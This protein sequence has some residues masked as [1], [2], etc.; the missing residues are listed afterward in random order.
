[1][2]LHA[3]AH[4]LCTY[5]HNSCKIAADLKDKLKKLNTQIQATLWRTT[6]NNYLAPPELT[7]TLTISPSV[8]VLFASAA[9]ALLSL[10][11]D[12][13]ARAQCVAQ[14]HNN[15]RFGPAARLRQLNEHPVH[16]E[17]AQMLIQHPD[18]DFDHKLFAHQHREAWRAHR[19]AALAAR[20]R[21]DFAGLEHPIDRDS[22][23]CY[24][25]WMHQEARAL[26]KYHDR[27]RTHQ[28]LEKHED[29]R[30]RL[31]II[32]ALLHGSMWTNDREAR[33]FKRNDEQKKC[34]CGA[35]CTVI[36]VS[37]HCPL[38][39]TQRQ[40]AIDALPNHAQ[41]P[42][43]FQYALLTTSNYN[44]PIDTI[45]AVHESITDVWIARAKFRE[46][47][48]PPDQPP[49]PPARTK[50]SALAATLIPVTTTK[51]VHKP[52]DPSSTTSPLTAPHSTTPPSTGDT[53]ST[54]VPSGPPHLPPF[55]H[56]QPNPIQDP[57]SQQLCLPCGRI[58]RLVSVPGSHLPSAATG[59]TMAPVPNTPRDEQH[60]TQHHDD[61]ISTP[62]FQVAT[63]RHTMTESIESPDNTTTTTTQRAHSDT[64][65]STTTHNPRPAHG[66]GEQDH[67]RQQEIHSNFEEPSTDIKR[68][69]HLFRIL[70]ASDP[71]TPYLIFCRKCGRPAGT[72]PSK[73]NNQLINKKV[74][75]SKFCPAS[76]SREE[77]WVEQPIIHYQYRHE[78]Q[79]QF[80]NR[81]CAAP[82]QGHTL[83]WNGRLGV[84]RFHEEEGLLTCTRCNQV[85]P[86]VN[87]S[88]NPGTER[89]QC[90][91]TTD[92]IRTWT[93]VTET[94]LRKWMTDHPSQPDKLFIQHELFIDPIRHR[95]RC[96]K[97]NINGFRVISIDKLRKTKGN[98]TKEFIKLVSTSCTQHHPREEVT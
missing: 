40:K 51:G 13:E 53:P 26:Q 81:W 15:V 82:I 42:R 52:H 86:T 58:E 87:V 9:D 77:D 69:G 60:I 50:A 59:S 36:H 31:A 7:L 14:Y 61:T 6:P 5:A 25:K 90:P 11:R 2:H 46:E 35:L 10:A 56:A 78:H 84:V 41:A 21:D 8:D 43:C 32:R 63:Q 97:C 88:R 75:D 39:R 62:A 23:L 30:Y 80:R 16:E 55:T 4:A 24:Y 38:W 65:A 64:Q 67:T 66:A 79:S 93:E 54:T 19:W 72:D 57:H 34:E 3:C 33:H 68:F 74:P 94:A 73:I 27:Q 37:W 28:L 96:A 12:P 1:M 71:D 95:W 44:L 92:A 22:S 98:V 76:H 20:R 48:G 49:P 47:H 91:G 83:T 70:P 85:W 29:P 18:D 89:T 45:Y 17:F